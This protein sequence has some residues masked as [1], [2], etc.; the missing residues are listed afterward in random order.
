ME[1]RA[2]V[3]Y[4]IYPLPIA[5]RVGELP[6][7]KPAAGTEQSPPARGIALP[8]TEAIAAAPPSSS[9]FQSGTKEDEPRVVRRESDTSPRIQQALSAYRTLQD[10]TQQEN[11]SALHRILGVDYYA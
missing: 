5:R 1:I 11:R 8:S 2:P 3:A 9:A 10:D 6:Q 7:A 4:P